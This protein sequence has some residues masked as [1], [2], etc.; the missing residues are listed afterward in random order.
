MDEP[1]NNNKDLDPRL[2]GDEGKGSEFEELKKQRDEYLDGWKRAKADFIN[3]KKEEMRHLQ[4]VAQYANEDLM[5]DLVS[6]LDNFDLGLRQLEKAGP[7]EKGVY[8][9]RSQIEDTLKRR[10]LERFNVKAGDE[11]DPSIAEAVA[12][13]ESEKPSGTILEEIEPGYK[14]HDKIIRP[15]RVKVTK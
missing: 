14:L 5:K 10:G 1:K 12:M 15:A 11:F 3:Y 8:M 6:V 4:E 9:I 7:V 2:R 13:A